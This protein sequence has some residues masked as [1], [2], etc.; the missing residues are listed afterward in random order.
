MPA[1]SVKRRIKI[2]IPKMARPRGPKSLSAQLGSIS[3][4]HNWVYLANITHVRSLGRPAKD[5]E[6]RSLRND[7][8]TLAHAHYMGMAQAIRSVSQADAN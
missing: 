6:L 8:S 1:Q 3:Q 7:A 4:F 2:L 5:S